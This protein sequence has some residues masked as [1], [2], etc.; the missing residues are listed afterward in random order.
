MR[1]EHLRYRPALSHAARAKGLIRP[2]VYQF[3]SCGLG[4]ILLYAGGVSDVSERLS[5][6]CPVEDEA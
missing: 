5:S 2:A 6:V 1:H 3:R 4:R